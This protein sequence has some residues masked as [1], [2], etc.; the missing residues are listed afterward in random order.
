[1]KKPKCK[2]DRKVLMHAHIFKNAGSTIDW[3]LEKNFGAAFRDDREDNLMIKDPSY[4][5]SL[6]ANSKLK[7]I[8]SHSLPLPIQEI[9]GVDLI[10]L[11]MLRDPLLR[12]R[13]V[14]NFER[15]QKANTPGAKHAKIFAFKE[16][17]EWRM[18]PDVSP[19]IRDMQVRYLTRNLPQ[20][21]RNLNESHL[22]AAIDLVKAT[23]LV[24]IVESFDESMAIFKRS[25]LTSG[26]DLNF[27]YK[28]QNITST[29]IVSRAETIEQLKNDLGSSLFE[30]V[31][32]H[33]Q[34]DLRLYDRAVELVKNR[35]L[36]L[37][38]ADKKAAGTFRI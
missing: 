1:M 19:T 5:P 4:L 21:G 34:F 9:Q 29:K 31:L 3:I 2:P 8:S 16:Y 10:T 17:V 36:E 38:D 7:A 20:S 27:F 25:L 12:I 13:S 18:N 14:Y 32:K 23:S 35:F 37:S 30:D 22:E 33:N 26:I 6:I 15:K 28:K 24:G 11:V